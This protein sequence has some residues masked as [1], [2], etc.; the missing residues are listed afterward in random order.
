MSAAWWDKARTALEYCFASG[1][2]AAGSRAG[3]I[4]GVFNTPYVAGAYVRNNVALHDSISSLDGRRVGF[5][6]GTLSNNYANSAM[7]VNGGTVSG[8]EPGNENGADV[9][10]GAGGYNTQAWWVT[11]PGFTFNSTSGPWVWDGVKNLPKL[12]WEE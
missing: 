11:G 8:G 7:T 3:G 4:V 5:S 2:V 12:Y 1:N 10:S 6:S 9:A